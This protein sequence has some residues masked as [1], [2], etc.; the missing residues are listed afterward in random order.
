MTKDMSVQNTLTREPILLLEW[1]SKTGHAR[2]CVLASSLDS[3]RF[4]S[5]NPTRPSAAP[6]AEQEPRKDENP[7]DEWRVESDGTGA[8]S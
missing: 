2:R 7:D 8:G 3:L 6:S 4:P 1:W 5:C